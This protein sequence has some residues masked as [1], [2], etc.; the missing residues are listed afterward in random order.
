MAREGRPPDDDEAGPAL[1]RF[2]KALGTADIRSLPACV[3][4]LALLELGLV[5][6]L[7]ED[8]LPGAASRVAGRLTVRLGA[9]FVAMLVIAASVVLFNRPRIAVPP[10]SRDEP[11]ALPL[12]WRS[13]RKRPPSGSLRHSVNELA[14]I[15]LVKKATVQVRIGGTPPPFK[16]YIINDA[17]AFFGFYP[18]YER[19]VELA[20]EPA[21]IYDLG[22]KDTVLFHHAVTDDDQSMGSLYVEQARRWFDSIWAISREYAS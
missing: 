13:R 8:A 9:G 15:G 4:A 1:V 17:Q 21:M 19:Q 20:D 12:W 2:G 22:G 5:A 11:G 16:L 18:V 10:A 3:A 6:S 14:E 7:L